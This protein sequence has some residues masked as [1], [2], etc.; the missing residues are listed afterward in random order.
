M[1]IYESQG[2][3]S[4]RLERDITP[5]ARFEGLFVRRFIY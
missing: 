2:G 1:Q 5:K 4:Q 3:I